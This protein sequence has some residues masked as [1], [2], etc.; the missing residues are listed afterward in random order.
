VA[1]NRHNFNEKVKETHEDD[2][3]VETTFGWQNGVEKLI[4]I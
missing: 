3:S 2:A 4:P 1:R